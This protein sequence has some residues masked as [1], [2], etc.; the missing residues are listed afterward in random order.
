MKL[1]ISTIGLRDF[2]QESL[3]IENIRRAPLT[4]ELRATREFLGL[5]TVTWQA[6]CELALVYE[7][8]KG[9]LRERGGMDVTVGSYTPPKGGPAIKGKLK[10]IL[11]AIN[12]GSVTPYRGHCLYESLH[13]FLDSNGRTGRTLWAWHMFRDGKDPFYIPFLHRFYYQ[14]LDGFDGRR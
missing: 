10:E 12:I 14:A 1:Y 11:E 6:M 7:P 4:Q 8:R 5:D 9:R 3:T 13:P 2:M